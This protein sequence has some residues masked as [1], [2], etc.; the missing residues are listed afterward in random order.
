MTLLATAVRN[1][2]RIGRYAAHNER[3]SCVC[4]TVRQKV[5]QNVWRV[6]HKTAD[7]IYPEFMYQCPECRSYSAVNLYF[8]VEKYVEHD[9][10]SM[11]IDA[12]KQA[13]NEARFTYIL[14]HA[15]LPEN[16]ILYDLGAGEGCFSHVFAKGLPRS[17]VFA[18]E[19]DAKVEAKFYGTLPNVAFVHDYIEPFLKCRTK[20]PEANLMVLTDVMEHVI[21]PEDVL[22]LMAGALAPGGLIYITVPDARTFGEPT[23]EHV[24][25]WRLNWRRANRT[26]QHLWMLEPA[27]VESLV[28]RSFDIIDVDSFETDIRK[29]SV[30]TT[31]LAK[32]R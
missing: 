21:R 10:G 29:D 30:Y 1:W 8:P 27:V 11:F 6:T 24:P 12:K 19:G 4:G 32:C 13:L 15:Q 7:L 23:P 26:C 22:A 18:V 5:Q 2:I 25:P 16:A 20:T 9:L 31:V 28:A 3:D 14:D 17:R